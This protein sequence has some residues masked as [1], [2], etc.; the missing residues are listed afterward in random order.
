M[1]LRLVTLGDRSEDTRRRVPRSE[2]LALDATRPD[3]RDH[4]HFRDYRLLSLDHDP[5]T[6]RPAVEVAHEA[7]LREWDRLRSWLDE[8]RHDIRQQ[9]LLAIATAEWRQADRDAGFLLRD[10][11]L[12]QFAA[13]AEATD[14]ALT[15]DERAFLSISTTEEAQRRTR[16]QRTRN[17]AFAT[18]T[19]VAVVLAVLTLFAFDQRHKALDEANQKAT[20]QAIAE[21]NAASAREL[22]LVNGARAGFVS[23]DLNTALALALAANQSENPSGAAQVILSQAAYEPGDIFVLGNESVLAVDISRDGKTA[24]SANSSPTLW[25]LNTGQ[26]IHTLT[27]H[28]AAVLDV[29]FSPDGTLVAS[30]GEDGTIILSD[31]ETGQM[32]CRLGEDIIFPGSAIS[33]D[34]SSDGSTLLSSNGGRSEEAAL[35]LW[36]VATGIPIREFYGHTRSIG[37]IAISP[38]DKT[39]ISGALFGELI[40]WDMETGE[41]LVHNEPVEDM[42][43]V[44]HVPTDI[45]IMPDGQTALIMYWDT[46][47]ELV[48]ITSLD[49]L[50]TYSESTPGIESWEQV[51]LS[52]DGQTAYFNN[53]I[54][55]IETGEIVTSLN[56]DQTFGADYSPDGN[57][58]LVSDKN[59]LRLIDIH[60]GADLGSLL[61]M[62][63]RVLWV[64]QSP[65]GQMLL[66]YWSSLGENEQFGLATL[67]DALTGEEIRQFSTGDALFDDLGCPDAFQ[68]FTFSPDG[69]RCYPLPPTGMWRYGM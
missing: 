58:I 8:S 7:I 24:I 51:A 9:R 39:A 62:S 57:S 65:D 28:D 53:S 66:T 22:A 4:R 61:E 21:D 63:A 12:D 14:I 43:L 69:R 2:L 55:N 60:S 64:E 31:F 49:I 29:A 47:T 45:D 37:D 18:I 52:P 41:I 38:D 26:L 59:S 15:D 40:L 10:A 68:W 32:V 67:S 36:D 19:I 11:R 33:F 56:L 3:G 27:G 44:Y 35:I 50:Q 25:D 6:R 5:D 1:F 23:R 30:A 13:W 34:F 54:W 46:A 20:A 17:A 42:N 48:D 16:R